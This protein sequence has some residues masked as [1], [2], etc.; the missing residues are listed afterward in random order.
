[1]EIREMHAIEYFANKNTQKFGIKFRKA[2][3]H[4][5]RFPWN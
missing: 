3:Y 5:S 1:M 2:T 4:W